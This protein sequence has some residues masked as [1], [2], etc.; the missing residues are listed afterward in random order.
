MS[1]MEENKQHFQLLMLYYFKKVKSQLKCK[2][3]CAEKVL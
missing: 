1:K 2:K 3:D